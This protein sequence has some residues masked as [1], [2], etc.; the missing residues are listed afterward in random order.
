MN[1][2]DYLVNAYSYEFSNLNILEC[3][4]SQTGSETESFRTNNNCYY[5]EANPT[6]YSIMLNQP[7]VNK[8]N[9][10]NMAL[11]S[12]NGRIKFTLT[13]HGG[14]SSIQHADLHVKE[15]LSYGSTFHDIE[16]ECLTYPYFIRN[17][18]KKPIDV[19]VLDIEGGE[20]TVLESMKELTPLECPKFF[21]IEAGYDWPERKTLLTELGYT[22]DFYQ[23]NNVY[24][25][26]SSFNVNKNE[27][28]IRKINNENRQ[29][30][31]NNE[32]IFVNDL[33]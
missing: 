25:T 24:L 12:N 11:Y 9:I 22:I 10:F 5:V 29:F 8:T 27:N 26:H 6:D 20:C 21:V 7:N 33:V 15:L 32:V 18:I 23:F 13:S 14:N 1:A 17:V 16:V 31:W 28:F 4:S 3:G 2:Y 19:L 30:V